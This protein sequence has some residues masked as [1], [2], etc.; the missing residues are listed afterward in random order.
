MTVFI[1]R[2]GGSSGRC[3]PLAFALRGIIILKY[4]KPVG[5]KRKGGK[6]VVLRRWGALQVNLVLKPNYPV[7]PIIRKS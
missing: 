6:T 3:P 2:S 1:P 7:G 4:T 5:Q